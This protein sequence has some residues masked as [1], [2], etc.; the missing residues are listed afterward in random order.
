MARDN[1]RTRYVI[2]EFDVKR[3]LAQAAA[4]AELA[5][6]RITGEKQ[7]DEARRQFQAAAWLYAHCYT[8]HG[9]KHDLTA[10]CHHAMLGC[11]ERTQGD[12]VPGVEPDDD[13]EIVRVFLALELCADSL[14]AACNMARAADALA[15]RDKR[16]ARA[17]LEER[18]DARDGGLR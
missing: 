5:T 18:P 12:E 3:R 17:I 9:A 13:R 10:D 16:K 14:R 7:R 6:A 2:D 11:Y 8:K 15:K 1:R 4:L